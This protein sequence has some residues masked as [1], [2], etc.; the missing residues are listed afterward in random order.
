MIERGAK[1]EARKGVGK[2]AS[3][4]SSGGTPRKSNSKEESGI[5]WAIGIGISGIGSNGREGVHW[6]HL[7]GYLRVRGS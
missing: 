7:L 3:G 5:A 2:V 4:R 1:M 6:G